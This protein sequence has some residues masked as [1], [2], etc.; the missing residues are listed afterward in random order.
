MPFE[1]KIAIN[2]VSTHQFPQVT[3]LSPD[4]LLPLLKF[5]STVCSVPFLPQL[6]TSTPLKML[7]HISI[8]FVSNGQSCHHSLHIVSFFYI[9]KIMST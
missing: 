8:N 6:G 9:F 2:E 5:Y 7:H 1:I 4:V 3:Q